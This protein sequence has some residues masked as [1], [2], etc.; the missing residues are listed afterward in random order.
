MRVLRWIEGVSKLNRVRNVDI[1]SRL[2][3]EGVADM[4][5][6]RQQEWKQRV[7]KMNDGKVAKMVYNGDGKR[8]R[9]T[10]KAME[11]QF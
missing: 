4:V 11:R 1:R 2:G 10:E 5:M 3:Q 8:P 6:R 7:E 9:E